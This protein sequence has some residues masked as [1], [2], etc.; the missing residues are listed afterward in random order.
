MDIDRV[1]AY[2]IT[3]DIYKDIAEDVE[4]RFNTSSYELDKTLPKVKNQTSNWISEI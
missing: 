1:I 3:K 4:I 2:V